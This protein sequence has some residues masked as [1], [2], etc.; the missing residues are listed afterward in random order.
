[1]ELNKC[2]QW[3]PGE[4]QIQDNS[5]RGEL[6]PAIIDRRRCMKSPSILS[7]IGK[8]TKDDC[9][10]GSDIGIVH[11]GQARMAVRYGTFKI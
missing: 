8:K 2:Q 6:N 1:M 10:R 9:D 11:S 5:E 3:C 7:C 4:A